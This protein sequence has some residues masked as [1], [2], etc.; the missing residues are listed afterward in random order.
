MWR[1]K[2]QAPELLP[3]TESA[4]DRLLF[5][6]VVCGFGRSSSEHAFPLEYKGVI[7][8][9]GRQG[10]AQGKTTKL[11]DPPVTREH[12]HELRFDAFSP[13]W[14]APRAVTKIGQEKE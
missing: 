2:P 8:L 12:W 5:S 6:A 13:K 14:T 7:V 10:S 9:A 4:F 1:Y 3:K 11:G